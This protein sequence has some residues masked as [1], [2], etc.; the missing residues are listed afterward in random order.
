[1]E[2]SVDDEWQNLT[3]GGCHYV[4]FISGYLIKTKCPT[5][6]YTCNNKQQLLFKAESL[7]RRLDYLK[8]FS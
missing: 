2:E 6:R 7:D 8:C 1:V 3:G 4:F 5:H